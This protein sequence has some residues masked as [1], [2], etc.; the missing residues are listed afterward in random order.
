MAIMLISCK[1]L[2]K[3]DV[4]THSS[5]GSLEAETGGPQV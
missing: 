3:E 4:V 5:Q 2:F 1:K